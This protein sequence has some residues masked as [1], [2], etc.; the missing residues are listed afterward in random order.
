MRVWNGDHGSRSIRAGMML[1]ITPCVS[2]GVATVASLRTGQMM[3][4]AFP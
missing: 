1:R 4:T 2:V 3:I